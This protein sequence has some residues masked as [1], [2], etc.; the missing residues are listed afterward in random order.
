[1]GYAK[2]FEGMY[3]GSMIGAGCEVFAVWG[4]AISHMHVTG[5][6]AHVELN[7]TY[8]ALVLGAP[9]EKMEEAIEY[10]CA[11]DENSRTKGEDG[12]RMVLM[13]DAHRGPMQFMVVNGYKYR[14]T[15]DEE[16]RR[17]TVR[18]ASKKYRAKV[19]AGDDWD[20]SKW[21]PEGKDSGLADAVPLPNA[22]DKPGWPF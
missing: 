11:P 6:T 13:S 4:Y 8:L 7:P 10:L 12:R 22:L 19:K 16:A 14:H 15:R 20:E 21:E 18:K 17:S 5:E 1:M 2:H 9:V 3:T